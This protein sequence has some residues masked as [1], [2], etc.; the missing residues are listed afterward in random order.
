MTFV[1]ESLDKLPSLTVF[2]L[3]PSSLISIRYFVT[4]PFLPVWR[5]TYVKPLTLISSL[6]SKAIQWG[7]DKFQ[8]VCHIVD[9]L[10]SN[11]FLGSDPSCW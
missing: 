4:F 2:Q 10:S 9:G 1:D 11:T 3:T 7:V 8:S 6:F 5:G